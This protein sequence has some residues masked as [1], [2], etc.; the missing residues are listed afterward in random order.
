MDN[1]EEE[2]TMKNLG[3]VAKNQAKMKLKVKLAIESNKKDRLEM[4]N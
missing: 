1:K 4:N 3:V 2:K